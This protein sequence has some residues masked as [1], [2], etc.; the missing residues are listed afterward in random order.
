[1]S[2]FIIYPQSAK[3]SYEE[4]DACA[5]TLAGCYSELYS[6]RDTLRTISSL[7][8][9]IRP[10]ETVAYRIETQE[11]TV[12]NMR[13]VLGSC[14][15]LYENADSRCIGSASAVK[16]AKSR[17]GGTA[18]G[19]SKSKGKKKSSGLW[20]W[21]DTWKAA[22]E[23]GIIGSGIAVAGALITGG[24]NPK[25]VTDALKY[26][27]KFVG[28]VAGAASEPSF[29]WTRLFGFNSGSRMSLGAALGKQIDKYKFGNAAKVSDKIAVG[30]KWAGS[31]LTIVSVAIDNFDKK[32]GNSFGRAIAET[33]GESAVKIGAGIVIGAAASTIGA[34]AVVTGLITVGVVWAA[35]KA[36]EAVTGKK[37]AEA[38]SD[39]VIDGV[40]AQGKR[41]IDTVKRTAKSIGNAASKIGKKLSG[42]W[43]R[44]YAPAW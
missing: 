18:S 6:I 44:R 33:I 11:R 39:F 20:T 17:T 41:Q 34:P 35:D 31:A 2:D 36:F 3:Q 27:S 9:V 32:S 12:K 8:G 38:I 7:S 10:I 22:K 19:P 16:P 29:D 37:A 26:T 23:A 1:M 24:V 43:N 21:K 5:R 4:F 40:I 13:S 15:Q 28:N 14:V 25:T 30:A 42:W